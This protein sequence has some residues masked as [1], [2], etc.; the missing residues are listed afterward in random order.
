MKKR[1]RQGLKMDFDK[2]QRNVLISVVELDNISLEFLQHP[3]SV[4]RGTRV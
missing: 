1:I 4:I 3:G 2:R